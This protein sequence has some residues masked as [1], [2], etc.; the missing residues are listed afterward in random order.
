MLNSSVHLLF[1][2]ICRFSD[3]VNRFSVDS[4]LCDELVGLHLE[5]SPT[6]HFFLEREVIPVFG[7]LECL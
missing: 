4:A 5:D 2:P 3:V 1:N 7:R 6:L